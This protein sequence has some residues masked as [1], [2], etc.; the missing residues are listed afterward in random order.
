MR[1]DYNTL[2]TPIGQAVTLVASAIL[3]WRLAI[4]ARHISDEVSFYKANSWDMTK[5]SGKHYWPL[6]KLEALFRHWPDGF[7]KLVVLIVR[8]IARLSI[9]LIL[10]YGAFV[11]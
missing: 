8:E 4:G 5:N 1:T 10:L 9:S 2:N 11:A 3:L 6:E 7:T